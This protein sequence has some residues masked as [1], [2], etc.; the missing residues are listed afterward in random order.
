MLEARTNLLPVALR[1]QVDPALKCL[2]DLFQR[3]LARLERKLVAGSQALDVTAQLVEPL[4]VVLLPLRPL[5]LVRP[6]TFLE[7]GDRPREPLAGLRIRV[8]VL[9]EHVGVTTQPPP[10]RDQFF[11]RLRRRHQ[12]LQLVGQ[13]AEPSSRGRRE[14]A[15]AFTLRRSCGTRPGSGGS[16]VR[17]IPTASDRAGPT[18]P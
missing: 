11:E 5:L 18:R 15:P 7:R 12:M 6:L 8:G 1:G 9:E 14:R 2:P 13:G 17:R 10:A 16:A 4:Q 3:S